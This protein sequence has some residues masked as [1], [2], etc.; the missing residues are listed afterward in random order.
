MKRIFLAIMILATTGMTAMADNP[1]DVNAKTLN[2][3]NKEFGGATDISWEA[4]A[5]YSKA[6]FSLNGS[7]LFAYFTQTG[8]LIAASRNISSAQLPLKLYTEV[9]K[10]YGNYWIS[11]LFELSLESNTDYYI[12]LEN[13]TGTKILRATGNSWELY[14]NISKN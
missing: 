9:K 5:A 4:T 8:E 2:T 7:I 11:D 14:K 1:K 12:T 13:A 10:D 6:T 3:F